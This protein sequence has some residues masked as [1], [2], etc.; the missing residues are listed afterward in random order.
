MIV[1]DADTCWG[2]P[3]INGT[4]IP[5]PTVVVQARRYGGDLDKLR[6]DFPHVTIPQLQACLDYYDQHREEI[7]ALM[8]RATES[9]AE[10]LREYPPRGCSPGSA[11]EVE[12]W[13]AADFDAPLDDFREHML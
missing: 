4:R 11:K 3:R 2:V 1:T 8:Q 6:E 9:Y 13:M 10:G 5:V 7:D 12:H